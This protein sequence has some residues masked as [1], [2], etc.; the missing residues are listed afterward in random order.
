MIREV[1]IA[2]CCRSELECA[3]AQG[4][5]WPM[6]D[7]LFGSAGA[8]SQSFFGTSAAALKSEESRQSQCW[9]G[10][11][12]TAVQEDKKSGKDLNIAGTPAFLLGVLESDGRVSIKSTINGARP[13]TDFV[14]AVELLLR[15]K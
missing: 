1:V 13:L 12:V 14:E 15:R 4:Q 10:I 3:A 6:H 8:L 5:F 2:V 7:A 9:V 11:G